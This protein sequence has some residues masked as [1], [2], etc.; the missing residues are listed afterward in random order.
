MAVVC[1][2]V[3][4]ILAL[5]FY[6]S[7]PD[8][9]FDVP[10]STVLEDRKGNL[11]GAR[12]AEDGQ[13]RFPL[14]QNVP[15]KFRIALLQFEDRRFYAHPGVDVPALC[16]AIYLNLKSWKAVSG[17]STLTM[18]VIRLSRR[19]RPRSIS[20]KL[21]EMLLAVRLECSFSKKEILAFYASNAPFGGNVVGLDAAAWR[22]FGRKP[23][24]LS[25]AESAMLAVL[26]NSPSL[27]HPGKNREKLR[28][29]RDRLLKRLRDVGVLDEET[30]RLALSEPIPE[31]PKPFPRYAF[32]L[33]ERANREAE[34]KTTKTCFRSTLDIDLQIKAGEIVNR[35][36]KQYAGNQIHNAAAL[37]I[38]VETGNVLAYIGNAGNLNDRTNGAQVD[39]I[40]AERSTGSVLKPFLFAGMLTSG[41]IL[42]TSLVPDIPT[43]FG[44]YMPENYNM[45]YDGA[46]PAKRALARSLNIPAIRMLRKYG[47]PK[48]IHL[49]KK[50]GMTTV[51]NTAEHSVCLSSSAE[52]KAICGN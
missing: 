7:L 44:G 19:G 5:L 1:S 10:V 35:Y 52:R 20:E 34:Q 31:R 32:H 8:P 43:Q 42:P 22:Y 28:N 48:F 15:D 24:D 49:L 14:N 45:G 38:E 39:I 6:L 3:C 40:T 13:W 26:P 4:A 25:W 27:I 18:Q 9:L 46:V 17:G 37:I 23:D 50:T 16:R 29:K 30:F 36:Q 2:A 12:I 11:L 21:I 51:N 33:L 41:D 47:I